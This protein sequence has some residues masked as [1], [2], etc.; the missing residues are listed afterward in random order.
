MAI[1][2]HGEVHCVG[3]S[4]FTSVCGQK[5]GMGCVFAKLSCTMPAEQRFKARVIPT[6]AHKGFNNR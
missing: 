2:N 1:S 4:D 3:V 5:A 6:W